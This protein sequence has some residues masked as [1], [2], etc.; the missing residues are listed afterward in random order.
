[1]ATFVAKQSEVEATQWLP[2]V[3]IDGVVEE[4][5]IAKGGEPEVTH[6]LLLLPGKSPIVLKEKAK[7]GD[8]ISAGR[9]HVE[10]PD[11]HTLLILPGD[12]VVRR[13][14]GVEVLTTE[15]FESQYKAR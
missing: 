9:A 8:V 4:T 5:K 7:V 1:M 12:W 15:E 13:G 14:Q 2:G 6:G 3:L 11:G 10:T